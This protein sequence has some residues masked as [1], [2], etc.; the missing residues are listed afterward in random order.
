MDIQ[1]KINR[2]IRLDIQ[3]KIWKNAFDD[4]NLNRQ[5][6]LSVKRS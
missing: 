3:D 6:S 1:N 4:E 5:F 2:K